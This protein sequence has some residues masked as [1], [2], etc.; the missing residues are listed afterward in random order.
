V[1]YFLK[2]NHDCFPI[3]SSSKHFPPDAVDLQNLQL[4]PSL[5]KISLTDTRKVLAR[6]PSLSFIQLPQQEQ[7]IYYY[8]YYYYYYHNHD[9]NQNHHH[10]YRYSYSEQSCMVHYRVQTRLSLSC[11]AQNFCLHSY[12]SVSQ[13]TSSFENCN[14]NFYYAL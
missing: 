9:H 10:Y 6:F 8:Y 1:V 7:R 13:V 12:I 5:N 4:K 11:V 3:W 2:T 14:Q